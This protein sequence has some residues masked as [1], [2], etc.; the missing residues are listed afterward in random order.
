MPALSRTSPMSSVGAANVASNYIKVME[1]EP[2][3]KHQAAKMQID[4]PA[5]R[6]KERVREMTASAGCC[7]IL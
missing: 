6:R 2:Y 1:R 7:I 5:M 3:C 4:A